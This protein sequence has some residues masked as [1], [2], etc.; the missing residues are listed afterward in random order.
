MRWQ[1]SSLNAAKKAKRMV[2]LLD[3]SALLAHYRNEA[4]AS[5]VHALFGEADAE[6]YIASVSLP[7]FARRLRDLGQDEAQTRRVLADYREL[8]DGIVAIDVP[9]AEASE[10]LLRRM[11]ARLPLVNALIAAA[12][13]VQGAAL[14]HR[15]A[16]MRAIPAELVEAVDLTPA[17]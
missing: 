15:D 13:R 9:V 3:T 8:L 6:L 14:V 4:G 5:R 16:H 11:P 12:A 7:E 10:E 2:Y 1:N 17:P